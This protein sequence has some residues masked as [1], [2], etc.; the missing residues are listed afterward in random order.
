MILIVCIDDNYGMMFNQRRQSQDRV[1]RE[2]LLQLTQ[3]GK[4]WMNHYSAKQFTEPAP[5]IN[6]DENFLAE[7]APGEYC[8]VEDTSIQPYYQWVEKVILCK[9][10]RV[11]PSDLKFDMSLQGWSSKILSEFAGSSHEKITVEEWVK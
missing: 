2:F 9:W 6:I 7:S 11:Y 8:F 5:Q 10:N 3:N 1:L 4:L